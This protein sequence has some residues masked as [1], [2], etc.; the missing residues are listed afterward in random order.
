MATTNI[1]AKVSEFLIPIIEDV[2]YDVWDIEYVRE[3]AD[4]F[5][6]ITIDSPNG[7]SIEDCEKVHR[8]IDPVLDEEDPIDNS[9][10][11]E[12]SSPGIERVLK[13]DAH[14][15]YAIG[16]KIELRLFAPVDGK[17]THVGI[18]EQFSNDTLVLQ[19][20]NGTLE[21]PRDKVSKAHTVFDF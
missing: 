1:V 18:L 6:R 9:Y 3:G 17:K 19:G 12:V 16:E 20:A 15:E 14:F 10:H 4:W 5:L 11:L 13:T 8:I 21:I 7:I 2:G